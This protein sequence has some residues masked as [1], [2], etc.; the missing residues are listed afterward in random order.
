MKLIVINSVTIVLDIIWVF[1]VFSVW[2][3]KIKG[4]KAWNKL[5]N[6][7]VFALFF[8]FVNILIKV[9]FE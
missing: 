5:Y 4:Y 3:T 7:H 9:F 1:S 8:S 6:L 2:T